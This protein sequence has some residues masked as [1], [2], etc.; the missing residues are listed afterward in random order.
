MPIIFADIERLE[1][2]AKLHTADLHVHSFGASEDVTDETMTPEA[3]IEAAVQHHVSLLCLT[4]HNSALNTQRSIDYA[5]G[6]YAG[7]I[8]VL[9]GVEI[10]T[11]HGHL[12]AY[13]D[14]DKADSVSTL[15]ARLDLVGKPGERDTH[16]RKSMADVIAEVERLQ[17]VCIA[18]HIDR[19]KTGFEMF[20]TGYPNWKADIITSSGLYGLEFDDPLNIVWFSPEDSCPTNGGERRKLVERRSRASSTSARVRLASIQNSDSHSLRAFMN[21]CNR[22]QLTRYK[23]DVL[24]FDGFKTALLDSYARVR[25]EATVPPAVPR[26][27]GMHVVGGFLDGDTYHFSDNLNCFIGG[28]GLVSQRRFEV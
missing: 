18:A 14:P 24:S 5:L 13:F 3:I 11:S 6:K 4:D 2:G 20:A 23:M 17:G 12:L 8:L 19:T 22:Q 10:T 7:Q 1:N 27:L 9:A 15:L 21:H 25:V 16:T 28:R 26:I